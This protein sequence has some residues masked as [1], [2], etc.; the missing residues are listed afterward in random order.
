M[1]LFIG[2]AALLVG[3]SRESFARWRKIALLCQLWGKKNHL[4]W[5]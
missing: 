1:S 5:I 3:V 4:T 2:A